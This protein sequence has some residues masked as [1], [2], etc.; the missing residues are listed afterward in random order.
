MASSAFGFCG[1]GGGGAASSSKGKSSDAVSGAAGTLPGVSPGKWLF[2]GVPKTPS[3]SPPTAQRPIR[4]AT[5]LKTIRGM[6]HI[7]KPLVPRARQG[8]VQ[9]VGINF[10]ALESAWIEL[11]LG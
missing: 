6:L 5:T 2:A 8:K 10:A 9:C 1:S 3:T 7:L 11:R 4:M